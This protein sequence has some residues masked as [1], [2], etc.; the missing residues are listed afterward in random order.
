MIKK[1][2]GYRI[3]MHDQLGKGAYGVV[4]ICLWRSTRVSSQAQMPHAQSRSLKKIAVRLLQI[5][6]NSDPYLKAALISEIK[7]M[8]VVK[9]VNI[10][11]LFDVMESSNNYYII[12]ELCDTDLESYLKQ[13]PNKTLS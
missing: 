10:V 9:S 13:K 12:Q 8:K 1:I 3:F 7:I 2:N 6:V 4:V 11:E 5:I